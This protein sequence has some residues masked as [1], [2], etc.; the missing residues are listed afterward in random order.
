MKRREFRVERK[1]FRIDRVRE[2]VS[3]SEMHR[4]F[5]VKMDLPVVVARWLLGKLKS[6]NFQDLRLGNIG[7][8]SFTELDFILSLKRNREGYFISLLCFR[9]EGAKGRSVI[10]YPLR[11][12]RYGGEELIRALQYCLEEE[13]P[14][15]PPLC[16]TMHRPQ[17]HKGDV[18]DLNLK[19]DFQKRPSFLRSHAAVV[20]SDKPIDQWDL[21][22]EELLI[23]LGLKRRINITALSRVKALLEF[24]C[25]EDRDTL[26]EAKEVYL[27]RCTL[28]SRRWSPAVGSLSQDLLKVKDRW[29]FL[30]GVPFHLWS[31][32]VFNL[33][34]A[35]FGKV[36]EVE[37]V[38]ANSAG[39]V[40]RVLIRD[41]NLR[42]VPAIFSLLD[43]GL[44]YP[45]R[46]TL[47]APAYCEEVV[48]IDER[49]FAEENDMAD[50]GWEVQRGRYR[51]GSRRSRSQMSFNDHAEGQL[52]PHGE[53]NRLRSAV[54]VSR[55]RDE[56]A[57]DSEANLSAGVPTLTPEVIRTLN[58]TVPQSQ[59][60]FQVLSE[61][62]VLARHYNVNSDML[63]SRER[64]ATDSLSRNTQ[65]SWADIVRCALLDV[66]GSV[67]G[68]KNAQ[69]LG[70][71][72]EE[73]GNFD[74]AKD[75]S[76]I[77]WEDVTESE[78]EVSSVK[79]TNST[80][81]SLSPRPISSASRVSE[82]RFSE[83]WEDDRAASIGDAIG[84]GTSAAQGTSRSILQEIN[85]EL[86][87]E[88][89]RSSRLKK[90]KSAYKYDGNSTQSDVF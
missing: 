8:R 3:I 74:A 5:A 87:N 68:E 35:G 36:T 69:N 65:H 21:L 4:G 55:H 26:L 22:E 82:T 77:E 58:E 37:V 49:R 56:S 81:F 25:P 32:E 60:R 10:Y 24:A 48:G 6:L 70:E 88:T 85:Q 61:S 83:V 89:R 43:F 52:F 78:D 40:H 33:I 41:C 2:W 23:A 46:I 15:H 34:C 84:F 67:E 39:V 71:G 44:A 17:L 76:L 79:R 80:R 7:S 47:E 50:I 45:V 38:R 12:E 20:E 63:E 73:N 11:N 28:T 31:S 42:V 72:I 13:F 29:I 9:K 30:H 27:R 75:N 64:H 53:P 86:R 66:A 51:S 59:N 57:A 1:S 19:S 14:I 16:Q 90:G 54:V 62:A 18:Q